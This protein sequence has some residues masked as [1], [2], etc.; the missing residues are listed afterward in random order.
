MVSVARS[1]T[2]LSVETDNLVAAVNTEGYV[3]GV[4]AGTLLDK[5]TGGRELG[6]GVAIADFLLEP[7]WEAGPGNP[8]LGAYAREPAVHG[9]IP[10]KYV[11]GGQICTQAR[12]LDYRVACMNG[13]VAIKQ[14]CRFWLGAPGRAAGST[15]EQTLV[16]RDGQRY[17]LAVDQVTSVNAVEQ[18]LLRVDMPGHLKHHSADTF[19][20]VYLSYYGR[21]PG[22]RFLADFAP[23]ERFL[24]QRG[25]QPLPERMIRAYRIRLSGGRPGPWLAGMTLNPAVVYDAW[26]HQRGYVCFIQENWGTAVAPGDTLR[27]VYVVG[28]FDSI[29]EM[30]QIYDEQGARCAAG[31]LDYELPYHLFEPAP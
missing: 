23:D 26:C 8:A 30:E 13:V 2:A 19:D 17:F 16:F 25:A 28:F 11:E 10:R 15:W 20:E 27:A 18:L 3:S 6:F 22:D 24:Y 9:S 12:R 5:G 7:G 1:G 29:S 4:A 21:I 14:W 31:L